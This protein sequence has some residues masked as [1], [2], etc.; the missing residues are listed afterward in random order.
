MHRSTNK[1][2]EQWQHAS[3]KLYAVSSTANSSRAVRET[4]SLLSLPS[5]GP[6]ASTKPFPCD[7]ARLDSTL[8]SQLSA[9]LDST[10]L[11]STQHSTL[12]SLPS[13]TPP[14]SARLNTR[15]STL[16]PA[17]L[18]PTQLDSTLDSQLSGQLDS[19][20]LG[21]TRTYLQSRAGLARLRLLLEADDAARLVDLDD[22]VAVDALLGTGHRHH[23]TGARVDRQLAPRRP[24]KL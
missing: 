21:S 8:D 7:P 5:N 20:R 11:S 10:R 24:Q 19:A 22:A 23:V 13:S 3:H 16:C 17:R 6:S 1:R 14:D 18:R 4:P 9:R 12:N 15:L 2:K